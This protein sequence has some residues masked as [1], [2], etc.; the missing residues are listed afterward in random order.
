MI[1]IVTATGG[2]GEVFATTLRDEYGA[3]CPLFVGVFVNETMGAISIMMDH[4][5]LNYV[6]L[7]G[8]ESVEMLRELLGTAYKAIRPRTAT[9]AA[10]DLSYFAPGAPTDVQIPSLLI[11][12]PHSTLYGGTGINASDEVVLTTKA[13]TARLMLAGGLTPENVAARIA[14]VQPW[15]VDVASGVESGSPGRKDHGKIR[16]FVAAA[17]GAPATES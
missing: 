11:D 4:V 9:E 13:A 7:S 5:G 12:A 3:A 16:A 8:D 15:G 6:Q 10:D 1:S 17:H 14:A 2:F